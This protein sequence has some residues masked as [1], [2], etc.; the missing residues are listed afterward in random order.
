MKLST[1]VA[2]ALGLVGAS[3]V[4]NKG[5]QAVS[6]KWINCYY[7][8]WS[9]YRPGEGKYLP[10]DIDAS[11]C[12][13]IYFS[14]AK[15]CQGNQGWTICP[16]EWNDKDEPWSEGM[17]T[18]VQN[19]RKQYPDLK[20]LLAIG[21]W[22]HGTGGFSDMVS[23]RPKMEA[24]AKN[25]IQYCL[26]NGFDG[27][28]LDWE[29]P[30][31]TSVDTSPPEDY[32]NYQI[33]CEVLREEI[34][35]NHP[36]F[37][38]TAAVGIGYDLI[39]VKDG[40]PPAYNP[41]HLSEHL[42][43]INL[44]AYDTHGH[45]E[46]KT[47]HQTL[48]HVKLEDDRLDYTDSI[49]WMV[50]NWIV[51]GAQPHKLSLGLAS[52]G[53]SFTL[54]NPEDHG[55]MAPCKLGSNGYYSGEPGPYTREP[56]YLAYYEICEDIRNKGWTEV[57]DREGQVPY[58]YG[59]DQWVGYDN[60]QSIEYKVQLAQH[61][62]LGGIMFWAVDIDDFRGTFCNQGKYPLMTAA[63]KVW[64]E[65]Y[66]PTD[67]PITGTPGTGTTQSTPSSGACVHGEYYPDEKDCAHYTLCA[68][69][70]FIPFDCAPGLYYDPV[71]G[72]CN[73]ASSVDCCDGNR[74]CNA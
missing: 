55:Y 12:T 43:M 57:W 23:S 6:P 56:G 20:V 65:G 15:M 38:L 27:I 66:V 49:E 16:Y 67:S 73:W 28:D 30:A 21:G 44:M 33:L 51:Q 1:I 60:V 29:Y 69:D 70:Q 54:L 45:W 8:N 46:D 26:E 47:G 37:L 17:Y 2:S 34:D 18:R 59:G 5:V 63:K 48:A 24:W 42:D 13:H 4:E 74:P 50:E 3:P 61:Y 35:T 36:G 22:N 7:T 53:R 25:S 31:K 10:E 62:N 32:L 9:Q 58:A 14:F 72:T 68:N 19:H 40:E 11:L 41:S 64:H 71:I 39:Y 52:Y